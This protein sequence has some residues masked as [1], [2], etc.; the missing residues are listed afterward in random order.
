MVNFGKDTVHCGSD[1]ELTSNAIG[2]HLWSNGDITS[3]ITVSSSGD[4]WLQVTNDKKCSSSDTIHVEL[5]SNTNTPNI[6]RTGD[7]ISSNLK[8]THQWF[9]DKVL[10]PN[11]SN[12]Y[13]IINEIGEYSA[14]HID[15]NGCLSDTSNTVSK[16]TGVSSLHN[17]P[18]VV[19]PN[20]TRGKITIDLGHIPLSE[21]K[22]IHLHDVNGKLIET[23]QLI[24][25]HLVSLEWSAT[26]GILWLSVH[27]EKGGYRK[28]IVYLRQ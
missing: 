13:L 22:S 5:V 9:K 15:S 23:K 24:E 25:D 10:V 7:S 28:E 18:I 20:P 16:T 17:L 2:D 12:N 14:V 27:T 26:P 1:L 6:T 21:I 19:Y 11:K 3:N 4:Y 8:G